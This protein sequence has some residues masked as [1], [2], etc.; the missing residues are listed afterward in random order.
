M[1][2]WVGSSAAEQRVEV[3]RVAVE[4]DASVQVVD[5]QPDRDDIRMGVERWSELLGECLVERGA[6]DAEVHDARIRA[7]TGAETRHPAVVSG[8][9]GADADRVGGAQRHVGVRLG[10]VRRAAAGERQPDH[11]A[12]HDQQQPRHELGGHAIGMVVVCRPGRTRIIGAD[13]SYLACRAGGMPA[14][15]ASVG[16]RAVKPDRQVG[17]RKTVD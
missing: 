9:R 2:A 16:H 15:S 11:R 7:E 17:R 10:C 1:R 3:L 14:S 12:A 13:V 4:R 5:G 8:V 6:A